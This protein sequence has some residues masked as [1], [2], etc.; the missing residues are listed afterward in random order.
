M[1]KILPFSE[2]LLVAQDH[3]TIG[4]HLHNDILKDLQ[5]FIKFAAFVFELSRSQEKFM[6]DDD[7]QIATT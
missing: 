7:G 4:F 3:L 2:A 1:F 6:D 5:N